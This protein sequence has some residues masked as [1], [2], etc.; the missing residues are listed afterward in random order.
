M[1]HPESVTAV[2]TENEP[3]NG[4]KLVV[5]SAGEFRVIGRVDA[6]ATKN[7]GHPDDRWFDLGDDTDGMS[8][9][10]YLKYADA[11]YALGEKL[12]EF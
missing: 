7:G 10:Q 2:L 1:P 3:A 9:H 5:S 8:L 12:A 4:T 11:V 6:A